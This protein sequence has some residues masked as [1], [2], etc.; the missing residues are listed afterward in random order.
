MDG[1]VKRLGWAVFGVSFVLL[2]T[3]TDES[4]F[5]G[6]R[7]GKEMLS[8]AYA[9]S[10]QFEIGVSRQF[11][12]AAPG[13]DGEAYS[14]YGMG[15]S[16]VEAV[17]MLL[18]RLLLAAFPSAPTGPLF[19]LVPILCLALTAAFTAGSLRL[20]GTSPAVAGGIGLAL[21]FASPLWG[22]AGSDYSEPVQVAALSLSLFAV[23]TLR[24]LPAGASAS[25]R[26]E[27]VAGAAAGFAVLTKSLNIVPASLLLLPALAQLSAPPEGM[28][29]RKKQ[30]ARPRLSVRWG[31]AISYAIGL[32][33]WAAIDLFRFGKL[34]GGYPGEDFP[35]PFLT[36]LL[37]LTLFPNKGLL[38]YAP[39]LLLA[40]I[41]FV[42]WARKDRLTA[43]ALA[44]AAASSFAIS[45]SW[46]AW[47]GQSGWGPRLVVPAVPI[48]FLFVGAALVG[49]RRPLVVLAAPLAAAG[50]LV[51]LPGALYP[52]GGAY[53]LAETTDPQPISASRAAG[54]PYEVF[55]QPDGTLTATGPHHLSLSPSW[56]PPRFHAR[57]IAEKWKGG[58]VEGR[59][60]A[61]AMGDLDPPFLLR[62]PAKPSAG[63]EIAVAP[64]R[65]PFWGRSWLWPAPRQIDPYRD[66][67]RDQLVRA[68]STGRTARADALR[69][70]L[71]RP[72]R[73]PS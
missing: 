28:K 33:L 35:Y 39:L 5:G 47:D 19:A 54:T 43:V 22:Y 73:P 30:E 15:T 41:G 50:F 65:W 31:V 8:A 68:V 71:N 21:V 18:S 56:W 48:L 51:N 44:G 63:F 53:L 24:T 72:F 4:L 9:L 11:V 26:W 27:V 25:R 70:A 7:D 3:T 67:M 45:A 42:R 1:A 13:P 46:W 61:G 29:K 34:F 2:L 62:P 10:N 32:A 17:P 37:R 36:G 49:A 66:A 58:D 55:Q 40:P 60:V 23:L 57:L 69:S 16:I 38:V 59:L 52:F 12:N 6:V 64:R 20:L 14:R